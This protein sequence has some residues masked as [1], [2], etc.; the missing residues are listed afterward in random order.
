MVITTE[1]E[2]TSHSKPTNP[3]RGV[4]FLIIHKWAFELIIMACI[5]MNIITMAM[6]FEGE[7]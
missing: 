5:V 3:F 4:I 7:S 2:F 1:N 6:T